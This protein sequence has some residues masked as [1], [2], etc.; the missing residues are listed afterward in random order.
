MGRTVDDIP[1]NGDIRQRRRARAADGTYSVGRSLD[2][3]IEPRPRASDYH[4]RFFEASNA[5]ASPTLNTSSIGRRR[6]GSHPTRGRFVV[7]RSTEK[8]CDPFAPADGYGDTLRLDISMNVLDGMFPLG[9]A[10]E[11]PAW[12]ASFG[13]VCPPGESRYSMPNDLRQVLDVSARYRS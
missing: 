2:C 11:L 9:H 7:L 10:D 8:V 6:V 12:L 5:A 13:I 3:A 1:G 4:A